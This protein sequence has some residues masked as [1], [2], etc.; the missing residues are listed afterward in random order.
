ME[1]PSSPRVCI[2]D[3]HPLMLQGVEGAFRAAGLDAVSATTDPSPALAAPDADGPFI[4]FVDHSPGSSF[5]ARLISGLID[6]DPTR[7]VVATSSLEHLS[8]IAAAYE[9]GAAAFVSK[10]APAARVIAVVLAVHQL[11]H[12]RDRHYPGSLAADLADYYIGGGRA[13]ASP[14]RLLTARQ[15]SIFRM[16]A[17][18]RTV[19]DVATTLGLNRRTVGNHLLAIR[20]RLNI[21]REHF[22]SCAIEHRLI[23]PAQT[24]LGSEPDN[25]DAS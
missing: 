9:A 12:P 18:G 14:R 7:R 8:M 19:K 6:T 5:G 13:D 1:N 25:T 4:Y 17:D 3:P 2:C 10:Q 16:V 11:A 15:L 22:R 20:R 21:P 23:D 24:R